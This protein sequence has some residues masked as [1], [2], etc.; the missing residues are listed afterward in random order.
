MNVARGRGVLER[1]IASEPNYMLPVY[2]LAE[3]LEQ[4]QSYEEAVTLLKRYIETNP[5]SRLYQMLADCYIRL[6][7]EKE[8]FEHYNVALRFL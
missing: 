5:S 3:Q 1:A 7:K 4:E 8:A 6:Q 2:L